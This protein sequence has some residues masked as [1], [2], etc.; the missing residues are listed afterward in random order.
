MKRVCVLFGVL[1]FLA[2]GAQD[3][4]KSLHQAVD[5]TAEN[6]F[7]NNIEGPAFDKKGNLYVVNYEKDGTIGLVR[8]DGTVEL[9]LTLPA[10]STANS[11][12]F[13]SKGTMY[14]ADFSGH[15]VLAV[16][17][18]TKAISTYVH[19]ADF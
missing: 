9:F 15:N 16:D 1:G 11:I 10:G 6:L 14:L 12:K 17:M 2:A 3:F 7:T 4:D 8:P 18:K 13:D 19:S 5:H